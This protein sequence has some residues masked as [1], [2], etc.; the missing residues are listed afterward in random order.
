MNRN[1]AIAFITVLVLAALLGACGL[2]GEGGGQQEQGSS[3]SGGISLIDGLGREVVLDAPARRVVS[4]AAST[5]EMLYEID[6]IQWLVGRDEFSDVPPLVLDLPDVGGAWGALNTELILTL[7]P[8]LV[9]AAEIH[10]PEQVQELE[11]LGLTVFW[12][13]NFSTFEGLFE[14]LENLGKLTGQAEAAGQRVEAL[15]TRVEAVEASVEGAAPV[16]VYYEVDGS[17]SSAPWT[18]GSETFHDVL[19]TMAGGLNIAA[20]IEGW[21]QISPE[22]VIA[23]DPQV[24]LFAVG[25]FVGSTVES[26]SSRPGWGGI[27]A[28]L[29][30]A[31]YAVD[32]NIVDRP[33][34]RQVA[35]LELF[36]QYFHPELYE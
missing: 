17:D 33:G 4:L 24:I 12:V 11:D 26:I 8:D 7:A 30:G 31:V 19:I 5:T 29:D 35:A 25:P 23:A 1:S 2:P 10:T 13:P 21:G 6:A 15:R 20:D 32:T 36:A 3:E 14:N 9:L 27:R 18:T 34:P 22:A 28:I 16:S